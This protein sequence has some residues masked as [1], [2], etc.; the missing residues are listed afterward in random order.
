M[1][2]RF[3]CRRGRR[4]GAVPERR[5]HALI[6]SRES[7]AAPRADTVPVLVVGAGPTGLTAATLLARRGV[8]CLV[9]ERHRQPYPLPRAVH[10][11]DEVLRIAQAA[12]VA[13][14]VASVCRPA[15]G[16]RLVDPDLRTLVEIRRDRTVGVHGWPETNMF[17]QPDLEQV[18]R[19][20]LLRHPRATLLT[21]HEVVAVRPRPD[22]GAAV[23]VRD[24]DIG[25]VRTVTAGHVLACDGANSP[26]RQQIGARMR[27]LGFDQHWLVVD[28]HSERAMDVWP[29]VHQI[30]GGPRSGT[31]MQIGEHRYRWEF[32][33][34]SPEP[35]DE[36]AVRALLAPWFP[37]DAGPVT[38]LR[39]TV[40]SHRATVADVWRRG[41]VFLLGDAAHL[42]PP[43]IGQGLGAGQ[44]DAMNLAWKLAAV[45]AGEA[46]ERLLDTYQPERRAHVTRVILGAV[47]VGRVMAAPPVRIGHA[48]LRGL[49]RL[50]DPD[51]ITQR[52]LAPR[53][54]GSALTPS[55]LSAPIGAPLPQW[56]LADGRRSDDL[57]G[58]GFALLGAAPGGP[59][60]EL[61]RELD[62]R[63]VPIADL[64]AAASWL[65]RH[66]LR[67][68]LIR[69]DRVVLATVD[70]RG[71]FRGPRS[72]RS[73]GR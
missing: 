49:G 54:R 29:G 46:D 14:E 3:E 66:R 26:L 63:R 45:V 17:D 61:V 27:D 30:C 21:G 10:L 6:G 34:P 47:L 43:F 56:V 52:V 60:D 25:G 11:D 19:S 40:Y 53:L 4:S 22:G 48:A 42:T 8:D 64:P 57:L 33:L 68:A 23:D 13:E 58:D 31:Y 72:L 38:V 73:L 36:A 24:L 7:D 50:P 39:H 12:G 51:P 65:S 1:D 44:R 32:R 35:V 20:N 18:L 41:P 9:V 62:A 16:M 37:P 15:L 5:E 67:A 69:P 28:V 70:G 59:L 71:R 2:R 55:A